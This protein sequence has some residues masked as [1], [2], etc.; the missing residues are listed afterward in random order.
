MQSFILFQ[1]AQGFHVFHENKW[2]EAVD[3]EKPAALRREYTVLFHENGM[4]SVAS[5]NFISVVLSFSVPFIMERLVEGRS[6]PRTSILTSMLQYL[7][8][9]RED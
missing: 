9:N 6:I 7:R 8:T 4:F 1:S 3:S 5:Q 2:R